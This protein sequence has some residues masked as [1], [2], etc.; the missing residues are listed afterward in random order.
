LATSTAH[1]RRT[2]AS[3]PRSVQPLEVDN[4]GTFGPQTGAR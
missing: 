3:V 4:T 2:V 1:R